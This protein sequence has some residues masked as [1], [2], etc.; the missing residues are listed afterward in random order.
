MKKKKKLKTK[1]KE[2]K[3]NNDSTLYYTTLQE[4]REA[5]NIKWNDDVLK[6]AYKD[7]MDEI[8]ETAKKQATQQQ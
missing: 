8:I 5:N 6:K 7:Y 2:R 3:L 4:I 1:L